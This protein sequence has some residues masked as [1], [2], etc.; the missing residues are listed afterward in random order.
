MLLNRGV[1]E[2]EV[3]AGVY[4]R[5]WFEVWGWEKRRYYIAVRITILTRFVALHWV[6]SPPSSSQI[7]PSAIIIKSLLRAAHVPLPIQLPHKNPA[8][9]PPNLLIS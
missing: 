9:N 8:S 1:G 3:R 2:G 6:E 5:L 7:Y 4:V